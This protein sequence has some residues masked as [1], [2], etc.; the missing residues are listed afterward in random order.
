MT[1]TPHPQHRHQQCPSPLLEIEIDVET[2]DGHA[3]RDYNFDSKAVAIATTSFAT[4]IGCRSCCCNCCCCSLHCH[5]RHGCN[6]HCAIPP[7]PSKQHC[8]TSPLLRCRGRGGYYHCHS[9]ACAG[10]SPVAAAAAAG[11]ALMNPLQ[12]YLRCHNSLECVVEPR[13]GGHIS[14]DLYPLQFHS[15]ACCAAFLAASSNECRRSEE[16]GSPPAV[17]V[18][19]DW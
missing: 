15:I 10:P 11:G 17:C 12:L 13:L 3:R 16:V 2:L 1:S 8:A 14:N 18:A 4:D 5:Y 19:W 6:W 9:I 7:L